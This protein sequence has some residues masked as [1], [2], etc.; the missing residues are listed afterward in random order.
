M[1]L[2]LAEVEQRI[3]DAIEGRTGE[4]DHE[5]DAITDEDFADD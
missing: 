5:P 1:R 3:V 4:H 2:H